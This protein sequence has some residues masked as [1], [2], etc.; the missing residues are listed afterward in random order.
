MLRAKLIS[1]LSLGKRIK[2]HPSMEMERLASPQKGPFSQTG[3]N[4]PFKPA[5][6]GSP[7]QLLQ[8]D[9][10]FNYLWKTVAFFEKTEY[11]IYNE[12]QRGRKIF[13]RL[14]YNSF[15]ICFKHSQYPSFHRVQGSFMPVDFFHFRLLTQAYNNDFVVETVCCKP[16]DLL[17]LL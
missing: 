9:V 1:S 13:L 7:M 8:F 10:N 16:F 5:F 6:P 15:S 12:T 4:N 2:T 14:R 3:T 11:N 17:P